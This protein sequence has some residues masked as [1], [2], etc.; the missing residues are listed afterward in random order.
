[1]PRLLGPIVSTFAIERTAKELLAPDR[2]LIGLYLDEATRQDTADGQPVDRLERPRSVVI[3]ERI[4]RLSDR[5]LPALIL[6]CPGTIGD[7][8]RDGDGRISARFAIGV[9]AIVQANGEDL[10]R[11]LAS[12]TAA[13]ASAL[14][15]QCLTPATEGRLSNVRF[16][17]YSS[18]DVDFADDARSR[19]IVTAGLEMDVADILNDSAGP[20]PELADPP[21][22]NPPV[23]AGDLPTVL[24]T[25][26]TVTPVEALT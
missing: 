6:N 22:G 7:P 11:E 8:V 16:Q 3:R 14:L 12:L 10:G 2:G 18:T 9:T 1:M 5:Q 25:E 4:T 13:A 20:P 19:C 24:T 26:L 21:L 23:D 17:G 15:L